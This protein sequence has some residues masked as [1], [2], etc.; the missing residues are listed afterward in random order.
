MNS[1][2]ISVVL[3]SD[4]KSYAALGAIEIASIPHI[5]IINMSGD[6]LAQYKKQLKSLT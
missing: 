5:S 3:M 1:E 4:Q 6:V 2:N